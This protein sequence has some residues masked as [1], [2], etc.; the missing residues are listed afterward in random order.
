[1]SGPRFPPRGSN[2]PEEPG[3]PPSGVWSDPAQLGPE[4]TW[5]SGRFLL[6]KCGAREIGFDDP[7]HI[8]TLAGSRAGKTRTILVPNLR[9]YP[10]PVIA[11]DPKGELVRH[12]LEHRK[13]FGPVYVL[14][15]FE[16]TAPRPTDA[17]NPFDELRRAPEKVIPADA[18]QI[19]EALIEQR[20]EESDPH[21]TNSARNLIQALI[22]HLIA[23][24]SPDANLSAVR[25]L[26]H[27][28]PVELGNAFKE[29]VDS[30]FFDGALA[31]LGAAFLSM[32]EH[33][34]NDT[35]IGYTKE[36]NSILSTAR[37]QTASLDQV[38]DVTNRS[39]FSL[40]DIGRRNL[41]IYLVLPGMRL[42]TH[43]RWLRLFIAQALAAMEINPIPFGKL[44]AWFVLEE[45]PALG[46]MQPIETAAGYMAGFGVKLWAVLQDLSQLKR[47]YPK[48][49]ETFLGNAG[50]IQAFGNVDVTTT[51]YLSDMLGQCIVIQ[52]SRREQTRADLLN[53]QSGKSQAPHSVPLLSPTE[54]AFHFAREKKRQLVLVPGQ[55]PIFM[56]RLP[57]E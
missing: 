43:H 46:H 32:M 14:D 25:R 6:G 47:H 27:G 22:L 2:R 15:P 5:Q 24:R 44:P 36:M 23:T 42:G 40:A 19:A 49:W 37:Q 41:T 30:P 16:V 12:T 28:A 4:W 29:M 18:A 53:N 11:I 39:S 31:N 21:W 38:S 52:E 57:V 48:S 10:G 35:P 17:H 45:F 56:D 8:V 3:T 7:R 13:K 1:M 33:S 34:E 51:R 20:G 55:N 50:V 9:R 26:L 54:I